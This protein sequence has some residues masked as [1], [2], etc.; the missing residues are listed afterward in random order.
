MGSKSHIRAIIDTLRAIIGTLRAI[1]HVIGL[2]PRVVSTLDPMSEEEDS[3][4]AEWEELDASQREGK[5][6]V[7]CYNMMCVP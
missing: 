2:Y 5:A 6:A 4:E 1:E 7:C 3:E